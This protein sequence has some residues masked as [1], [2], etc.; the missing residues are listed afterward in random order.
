MRRL[1]SWS[2]GLPSITATDGPRHI[3]LTLTRSKLEEMMD[4]LIQP[5][6]GP[7]TQCMKDAQ[8]DLKDVDGVVLVG[9]MT[10]MP[11]VA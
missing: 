9:G 3:L 7:C 4:T 10:R 5:T 1:P 2:R 6:L 8:I 11:K